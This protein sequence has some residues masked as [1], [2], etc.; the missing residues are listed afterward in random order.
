MFQ[1]GF[2][3][4]TLILYSRDTKNCIEAICSRYG[5]DLVVRKIDRNEILRSHA[6]HRRRNN[7]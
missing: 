7:Q 3:Q 6:I 1:R 4:E 5:N 2:R